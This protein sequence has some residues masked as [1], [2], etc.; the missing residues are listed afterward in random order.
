MAAVRHHDFVMREG[1]LIA[2]ITVQNLAGVLEVWD[3]TR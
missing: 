3:L 2:F 1:H